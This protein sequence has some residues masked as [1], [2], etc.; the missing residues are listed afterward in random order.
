MLHIFLKNKFGYTALPAGL[1]FPDRRSNLRCGQWK[2][3][4]ITT[5]PPAKS[6]NTFNPLESLSMSALCPNMSGSQLSS[7]YTDANGVQTTTLPCLDHGQQRPV[8][9]QLP[10]WSY[11]ICSLPLRIWHSS[12]FKTPVRDFLGDPVV[13]TPL[14]HCRAGCGFDPQSG[15]KI[16]GATWCGQKNNKNYLKQET[17]TG[18]VPP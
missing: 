1:G 11:I 16:P 17:P 3:G 9:F 7:G 10:L 15:T 14:F 8:W 5:G 13:R 12:S 2:R 4:V 18:L 6:L